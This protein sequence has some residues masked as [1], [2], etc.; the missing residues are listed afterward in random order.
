MGGTLQETASLSTV[1]PAPATSDDARFV[2]VFRAAFGPEPASFAQFMALA[3]YHPGCGYYRRGQQRVGFAPQADFY[4]A[5]STGTVFGE[6]VAAA[7]TRLLAPD[8]PETQTFVEIGAE[9][10]TSV[11]TGVAHR[12][13]EVRTLRLGDELAPTGDSVVFSNELFDAQP[14]HRL[15]RRAGAWRERGVCIEGS[16]PAARLVEIE[17][18]ELSPP[19]AAHRDRLPAAA[20]EGYQLDLPLAAEAL[21]ARIAQ[22]GWAGLFV[23]FDYGKPWATLAGD[24]PSGTAR[25]YRQHRQERDLLAS[26]GRQDLTCHI[27]WDWLS[28]ALIAA[29]WSEVRLESQESFLLHHAAAAAEHIARGAP[30]GPDPRRSR[31]QELLH[32]GL[33]GQRFQ[34]LHAR[35]RR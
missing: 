34:V 17:L 7:A 13:R 28:S 20:D 35:R 26:P 1:L 19:V 8:L 6:L 32:P 10:H 15:V 18:P 16:G 24:T 23:A 30:P 25:A 2:E 3:L 21:C 5:S 11:L 9:P 27:C 4:T 33:L 31:L 29:G 12:F 14:F 22:P